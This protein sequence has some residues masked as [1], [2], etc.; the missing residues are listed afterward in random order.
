MAA[1]SILAVD[2][3]ATNRK[4]VVYV[5]A[6]A[7][8]DVLEAGDAKEALA[9]LENT[10][11]DLILMDIQMPGMDGLSLTRLIKAHPKYQKVR[12]V[13]LT[14]FAMPGDEEKA[15]AAGCDGYIT[16]PIDTFRLPGQI[17]EFLRPESPF[18][19]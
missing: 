10:V 3:N 17:A 9:I 5:L 14:A 18:E 2:D 8:V 7:D 4:L 16:K 11:P 13:A 6:A 15:R 1:I 19:S 12:V